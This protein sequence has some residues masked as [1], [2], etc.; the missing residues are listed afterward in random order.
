MFARQL[1]DSNNECLKQ[2]LAERDS[3]EPRL[4][5]I[6]AAL[7]T[8]EQAEQRT[9]S[10]NVKLDKLIDECGRLIREIHATC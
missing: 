1:E 4:A 10:G 8:L 7:A 6:R 3:F 2:I 5:Q 9:S